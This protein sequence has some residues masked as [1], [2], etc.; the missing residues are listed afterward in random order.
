MHGRSV[1]CLQSVVFLGMKGINK[2]SCLY[3]TSS[4]V[5]TSLSLSVNVIKEQLV[6]S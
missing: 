3:E 2:A 6:S 1:L 5:K 4:L